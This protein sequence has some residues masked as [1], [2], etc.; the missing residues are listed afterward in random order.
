MTDVQVVMLAPLDWP[1]PAEH[2]T[3]SWLSCYFLVT[4]LPCNRHILRLRHLAVVRPSCQAQWDYGIRGPSDFISL[5][6]LS[7]LLRQSY[8]AFSS[9]AD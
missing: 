3:C 9:P 7:P 4:C 5:R 2:T 1:S 6:I 8:A